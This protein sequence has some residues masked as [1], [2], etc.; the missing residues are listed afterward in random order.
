MTTTWQFDLRQTLVGEFDVPHQWNDL[1]EPGTISE[2]SKEPL[3][4]LRVQDH[5]CS[6]EV[7]LLVRPEPPF[8]PS[9]E[10][11]K[12]RT[13]PEDRDPTLDPLLLPSGFGTPRI[14]SQKARLTLSNY[15]L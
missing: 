10:A 8:D 6:S 9:K 12:Y 11:P 14:T 5:P 1:D 2:L 3:S 13:V 7:L 4:G 15:R